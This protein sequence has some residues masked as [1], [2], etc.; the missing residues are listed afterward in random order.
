MLLRCIDAS[1]FVSANPSGGPARPRHRRP[2]RRAGELGARAR[3]SDP[4]QSR[5]RGADARRRSSGRAVPAITAVANGVPTIG[6]DPTSSRGFSG[7]TASAK[8]RRATFRSRCPA[9]GR[10]DDCRGVPHVGFGARI[11][12]FATG[13]IGGVHRDAPFDESADLVELARTPM[14][15]VCAGAK[16]I[17]DLPAT[18]ER[19]ETLGVPVIGYQ[20]DELPGFFTAETG[21]RLGATARSPEEIVSMFRAHRALGGAVGARRATAASGA[22]AAARAGRGG[23]RRGSAGGTEE[24]HSRRGADSVSSR[25]RKSFDG[26]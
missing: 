20:T 8:C 23:G 18:W 10:S 2:R 6:L 21:I 22:C 11:V 13:G 16:S 14:L 19:L 26:W 15:V 3:A 24:R 4:A 1:A 9:R 17:L 5:R 12:V 7:A 25:G